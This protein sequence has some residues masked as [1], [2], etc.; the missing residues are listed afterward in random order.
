MCVCVS[1]HRILCHAMKDHIVRVAN[2]ADFILSKQ[3]AEDVKQH[4]VFIVSSCN[5][6]CFTIW[7]W[8]C[9]IYVFYC[10]L[11]LFSPSYCRCLHL[12][13]RISRFI[14]TAFYPFLFFNSVQSSSA[15]HLAQQREEER[16]CDQLIA[17]AKHRDHAQALTLTNK[18]ANILTNKLGAWGSDFSR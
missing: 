14:S 15:V 3:R 17:A 12:R 6:S 1:L 5:C 4:A 10:A 2:E 13:V 18:I 8:F 9:A 11:C 16:Q 7:K